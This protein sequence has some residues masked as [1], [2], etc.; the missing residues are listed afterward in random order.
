[1][2]EGLVMTWETPAGVGHHHLMWSKGRSE[3]PAK[4]WLWLW[5]VIPSFCAEAHLCW[6]CAGK[7]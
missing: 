2:L 6:R 1:M 5:D 3:H 4:P 7:G